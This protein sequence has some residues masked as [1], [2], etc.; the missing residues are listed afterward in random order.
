MA[1]QTKEECIETLRKSLVGTMSTGKTLVI[2]CSKGTPD[3]NDWNLEG[4]FPVGEVL[5]RD[6]WSVRDNY[7][8]VVRPEENKDLSGNEGQYIMA[9]DYCIIVLFSYVDDE[10]MQKQLACVPGHENFLKFIVE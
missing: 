5:N 6:T 1:K 2:N 9:A 10:K 7:I 3:F 8:K 4:S